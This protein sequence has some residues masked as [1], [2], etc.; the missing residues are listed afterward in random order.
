MTGNEIDEKYSRDYAVTL[1]FLFKI[2]LT[3]GLTL[4]TRLPQVESKRSRLA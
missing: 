2:D 1:F 4:L 3:G